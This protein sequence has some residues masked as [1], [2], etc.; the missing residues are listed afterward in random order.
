MRPC[1]TIRP[2]SKRKGKRQRTLKEWAQRADTSW[3][4]EQIDW[5]GGKKKAVLL[6]SHQAL[7]YTPGWDPLPIR[8]VIVR[9]P[10]GKLRDEVFFSTDPD[11][12]PVQM[13]NW[14]V[15]RWSV[16]TTF[17]EARQHLGMETQRQWSDLAIQRTTPI[18]LG[19]FSIVTWITFQM[20]QNEVIPIQ[21]TAWYSKEK[22]TFS[23]C[24]FMVRKNIWQTQIHNYVISTGDEDITQFTPDILDLLLELGYPKAA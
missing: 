13:I 9:D 7:W 22:G 14:V 2:N 18:L 6:F 21:K 4:A 5:Y 12:D 24:L 19:L 20:T 15:M 8:L 16:E 17:E 1:I 23:D 3:V 10:E 11:T